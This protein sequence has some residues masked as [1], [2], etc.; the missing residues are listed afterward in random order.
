MVF[1]RINLED[2]RFWDDVIQIKQGNATNKKKKFINLPK[3]IL[4]S[5]VQLKT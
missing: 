5:I 3:E 1:C 2:I 4:A